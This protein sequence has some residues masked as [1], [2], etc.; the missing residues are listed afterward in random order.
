MLQYM[1]RLSAALSAT[2][3][4]GFYVLI[5]HACNNN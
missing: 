2:S 5:Y 1:D 3:V 4:T